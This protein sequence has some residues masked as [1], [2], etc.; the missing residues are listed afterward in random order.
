MRLIAKTAFC[1]PTKDFAMFFFFNSLKQASNAN[2]DFLFACFVTPKIIYQSHSCSFC[3][4]SAVHPSTDICNNVLGD[5]NVQTRTALVIRS[6][7]IRSFDNSWTEKNLF[8]VCFNH[9]CKKS[10]QSLVWF[11]YNQTTQGLVLIADTHR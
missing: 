3:H 9:A 1:S 5:T 8:F 2:E 6:H 7:G 10:L 4:L 11:V